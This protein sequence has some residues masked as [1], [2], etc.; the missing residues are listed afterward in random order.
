MAFAAINPNLKVFEL[1]L[2]HHFDLN[3]ANR[4][5]FN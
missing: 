5:D 4:V 1:K 3:L 2:P